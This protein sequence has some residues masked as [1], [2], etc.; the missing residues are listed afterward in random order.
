[1]ENTINGAQFK[2]TILPLFVKYFKTLSHA[3]GITV[4][5]IK[6]WIIQEI[7][8]FERVHWLNHHG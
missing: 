8:Q 1:M 4:V 2:V 3:R 5:I 6:N 7:K